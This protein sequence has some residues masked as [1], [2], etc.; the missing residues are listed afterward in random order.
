MNWEQA[1]REQ[2]ISYS[3]SN[4]VIR[5]KN[6]DGL[7]N[8]L[9]EKGNGSLELA[10]FLRSEYAKRFQ[11]EIAISR[12]SLAIEILGH[13]Y[14]DKMFAAILRPLE[15]SENSLALS[16]KEQLTNLKR[17]V[18]VIDCGEKSED[19][20]RWVWDFLEPYR[21]IIYGILGDGA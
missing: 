4:K 10:D 6:N 7:K 15:N 19:T 13:A 17:H 18:D 11:K 5:L 21:K 2:D 8:F 3:L 12:D 16:V 14:F 20:N 1:F 9:Q